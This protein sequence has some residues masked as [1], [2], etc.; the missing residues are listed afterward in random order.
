MVDAR[1]R[2]RIKAVNSLGMWTEISVYAV[3]EDDARKKVQVKADEWKKVGSN[4]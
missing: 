1:K 4:A 2:Y 3:D